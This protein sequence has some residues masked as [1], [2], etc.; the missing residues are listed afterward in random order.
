MPTAASVQTSARAVKSNAD[1]P[2]PPSTG[3]PVSRPPGAA[4]KGQEK[5]A[6]SLFEGPL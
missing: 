3:T 2:K 5:P 4:A 6:K 1:V